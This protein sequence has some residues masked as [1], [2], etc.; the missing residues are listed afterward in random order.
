MINILGQEFYDKKDIMKHY[1]INKQRYLS[2]ARLIKGKTIGNKTYYTQ[3]EFDKFNVPESQYIDIKECQE[4]PKGY[5]TIKEVKESLGIG[6]KTLYRLK[7]ENVFEVK[8]FRRERKGRP[9]HFI[10]WESVRKYLANEQEK[11]KE[12]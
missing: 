4:P 1:K 10:S 11:K 2:L 12:I 3:E 6:Y 5:A 9:I 7:K 8:S